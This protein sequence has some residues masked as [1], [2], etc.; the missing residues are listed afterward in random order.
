MCLCV[1]A[2]AHVLAKALESIL[3][4]PWTNWEDRR[5]GNQCQICQPEHRQASGK[6]AAV[7]QLLKSL[8]TRAMSEAKYFSTGAAAPGTA[9]AYHYG[10]ALQFYTHF[11]SPI[12]RYADVV[13]HRQLLAALQAS[14]QPLQHEQGPEPISVQPA[15]PPPIPHAG[16]PLADRQG[17]QKD[18]LRNANIGTYLRTRVQGIQ[19]R[20]E[21]VHG[22]VPAAAAAFAAACGER[23]PHRLKSGQQERVVLTGVK[24]CCLSCCCLTLRCSVILIDPRHWFAAVL[25]PVWTCSALLVMEYTLGAL[26]CLL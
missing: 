11:T 7:A 17:R 26:R 25:G 15:L 8:T 9:G 12:R 4:P 14:R 10:L 5:N 2:R 19:G 24:G 13:A 3:F 6:D 23:A 16:T 18:E 21:G 20:P 1:C 22:A